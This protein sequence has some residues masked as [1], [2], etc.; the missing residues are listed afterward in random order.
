VGV[1]RLDCGAGRHRSRKICMSTEERSLRLGAIQYRNNVVR[2][3]QTGLGFLIQSIVNADL[4]GL[5]GVFVGLQS[6]E[7]SR[8]TVPREN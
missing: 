7:R 6:E 2:R 1:F 5:S 8:H 4:G 3:E